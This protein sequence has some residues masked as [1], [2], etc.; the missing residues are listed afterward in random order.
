MILMTRT[1]T[2][3]VGKKSV[4]LKMQ[5]RRSDRIWV[6]NNQEFRADEL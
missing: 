2:M 4:G 6:G 3:P 5:L 1:L